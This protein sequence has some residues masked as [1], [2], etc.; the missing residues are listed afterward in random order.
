MPTSEFQVHR[1]EWGRGGGKVE[2]KEIKKMHNQC[3]I[4]TV[5]NLGF[6]SIDF[7]QVLKCQESATG[8]AFGLPL[9]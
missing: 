9:T 5:F 2:I 8:S 1:W 6:I 7:F 3:E 4:S